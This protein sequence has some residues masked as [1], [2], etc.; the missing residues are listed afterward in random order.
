MSQLAVDLPVPASGAPEPRI[1][2]AAGSGTELGTVRPVGWLQR[3]AGV[4]T[5]MLVA[6]SIVPLTASLAVVVSSAAIIPVVALD[7]VLLVL[8]LLDLLLAGGRVEVWRAFAPVQAVGRAFEVTV[9]VRNA[10]RRMLRVQF[11]DDAPGQATGLPGWAML[12]SGMESEARYTVEID[13]RGQHPFGDV[14]VRWRSPLGLWRR[15]RRYAVQGAV[16][17]YPDF[18]QLREFG[19]RGRLSEDRVPVRSRRRPGGENE[20]QRLRP[21]VQGDP[22]RHI[23]WKA[24]AKRREYITREF[25]QESN[26]NLI[27]LL[28]CG[29]MMSARSGGLTAFDH[30]LNAAILMGQ[31]ALKHGDRVGLLAFDSKPRVWLPPRAGKRSAGRLI[32]A[33][34]DL[35]PSMEEPD[36]AMAFRYLTQHVRRRS[37]VVLFSSVVDQVNAEMST[38]LVSAL[39]SR[40]LPLAVWIRDADVDELLHRRASNDRDQYVQAAAADLF[41]QR[42]QALAGLRQRGAL[43]VDGNPAE[44]TP[45]LLHRYLE[46]KARRLL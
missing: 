13:R 16:R 12:G 29:R 15:Q 19:M 14:V 40:H 17:V 3:V 27:F 33:T 24:T 8:A 42:D 34:Y 32:R 25:G 44:V 30:A 5:G 26:Q 38:Q 21:Y 37:L 4:P 35:F 43:V 2:A 11:T 46:I 7:L 9:G 1:G 39:S 10:G 36:Y 41:H 23:D 18:G 20:F 22:Y 31:V 45:S 28:D 6:L